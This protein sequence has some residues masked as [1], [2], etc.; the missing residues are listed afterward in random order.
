MRAPREGEKLT[1]IPLR[2]AEGFVDNCGRKEEETAR[3]P[4]HPEERLPNMDQEKR[5]HR[6]LK[7][8]VKKAGNRRRRQHLKR[9]LRD[10]PEDAAH[11]EPDVGRHRSSGLNGIDRDATRRSTPHPRDEEE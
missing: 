6:E 7:R 11:T 2:E 9:D 4:S 5:R 8:E 3:E 10:N 1:C